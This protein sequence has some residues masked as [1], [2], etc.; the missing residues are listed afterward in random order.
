MVN[1]DAHAFP[2]F[3]TPILT[4][5]FFKSHR[6]VFSHASA[7]VRGENTP[8]RERVHLNQ[9]SS[10]KP[11]GNVSDTLTTELHRQ[12]QLVVDEFKK[13]PDEV[14]VCHA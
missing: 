2:S 8:G 3:L 12:D 7:E 4:Q 6:L 10:S 14:H 5:L 1:V 9:V 13:Y 11:P